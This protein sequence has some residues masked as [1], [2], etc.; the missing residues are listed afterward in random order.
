MIERN[1]DVEKTGA[2]RRR[3]KRAHS[4]LPITLA[5]DGGKLEAKLRD[6][7]RAGV[8]FYLE[9]SIPL[10]TVLSIALDLPAE[11]ATGRTRKVRGQGAV[12]RCERISPSLSHWEVAL[13]L[14]DMSEA[15]RA[16]LDAYVQGA[17]HA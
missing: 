7:S 13:F 10:M 12:V 15:D 9:R 14:H 2:D 16:A 8:C 17:V 1:R 5:L 6:V 11:A 3:W 4:E